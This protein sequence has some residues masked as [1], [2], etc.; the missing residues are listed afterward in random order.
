MYVKFCQVLFVSFW[1]ALVSTYLHSC[2]FIFLFCLHKHLVRVQLH[3]H[4][5]CYLF[6]YISFIRSEERRVGKECLL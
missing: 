6:I 4:F 3:L 5:F 2:A 1:V